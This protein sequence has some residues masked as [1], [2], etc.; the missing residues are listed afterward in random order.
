[1]LIP[2]PSSCLI[3]FSV[4]SH[5]LPLRRLAGPARRSRAGPR[6]EPQSSVKPLTESACWGAGRYRA[7]FQTQPRAPQQCSHEDLVSRGFA[8]LLLCSFRPRK[9]APWHSSLPPPPA[10]KPGT[11]SMCSR[12]TCLRLLDSVQPGV[13]LHP[14]QRPPQKYATQQRVLAWGVE[15]ERGPQPRCPGRRV[16][17]HAPWSMQKARACLR[18]KGG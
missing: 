3:S 16:G 12:Q 5:F 8:L 7:C 6:G 2:V 1:M 14:P 4:L 13:R 9:T 10:R 11:D 15:G 17:L 18:G